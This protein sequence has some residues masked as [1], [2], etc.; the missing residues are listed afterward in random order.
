M[1]LPIGDTPNPDRIP[2]AN[3]L[4]IVVNVLVFLLVTMPLAATPAEPAS[5]G[6][7]VEVYGRLPA[8]PTAYDAFVLEY[9]FQTAA[10]SLTDLFASL[11]LH[12]GF[13]HLFGNML[14]LWIYGDNVEARLGSI[15]YLLFYL[16]CGVAATLFYG[17]LSGPSLVPLVGAS[18][19]ISGVL[20][21]YLV[22]FPYNRVKLLVGFWPLWLEVVLVPAWLVLSGY[23]LVDNLLPLLLQSR[24]NVAY[25][26]H[27]GGFLAGLVVSLVLR[28]R[29]AARDEPGLADLEAGR[30]AVRRG[31]LP[32]G[33]QHLMRAWRHGSPA[34]AEQA[35]AELSSLPDPRLRAWGRRRGRGDW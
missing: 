34:V 30:A 17:V 11:F 29:L 35:L 28:P 9:G 33:Y 19:A 31:D 24:S 3:G 2:W 10:P 21:A 14:F 25:G 16:G 1:I 7:L 15:P 22:W 13:A 12:A 4:L 6:A 5:V 18:G 20:G 26:A 8:L 32:A 23:L 27:I